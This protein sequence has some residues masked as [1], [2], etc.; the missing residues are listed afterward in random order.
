MSTYILTSMFP[1]G[2]PM[3]IAEVFQQLITNRNSFAFIASEFE[4]M[5]EETDRYFVYFLNM[6][7]EQGIFFDNEYVVDA[8]MTCEEA[9]KAV[10][11]ADVVWISGG[12]T[13]TEFKYLKRYGLDKVVKQHQGVVIGLSAGAINLAETAICTISCQH[14]KQEIYEGLGCVNISVEPHFVRSQLS[15]E[16]INLSKNFIIYGLC[17]DAMIVCKDDTKYFFGEVYEIKD[18]IAKCIKN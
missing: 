17:D 1:N 13:S 14:D 11:E 2:F 8:S 15:D 16:V 4:K 10:E 5:H 18:G 6:F 12:D 3:N 9:Q 7:H